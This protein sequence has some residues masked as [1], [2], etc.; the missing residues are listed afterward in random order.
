MQ[1]LY[2]NR[3]SPIDEAGGQIAIVRHATTHASET[4]Q[5][6]G[7][8]DEPLLHK[9]RREAG[10]LAGYLHGKF[11]GAEP[12]HVISSGLLRADQTATLIAQSLC[13]TQSVINELKERRF[14]CWAGC[15]Y[16]DIRQVTSVD[17][18]EML[19][20]PD[21]N[22]PIGCEA[23]EV[24]CKRVLSGWNDVVRQLQVMRTIIVVA[25]DG[26]IRIILK[27]LGFNDAADSLIVPCTI[28]CFVRSGQCWELFDMIDGT[29]ATTVVH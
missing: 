22:T 6:L 15:S 10:L 20:N 2:K 24:F 18:F 8:I 12:G 23:L 4:G 28:F 3:Q 9:G 11:A 27:E 17:P 26:P 19:R 29:D 5:L 1:D 7:W 16:E 13:W 21:G 25:H 14:G